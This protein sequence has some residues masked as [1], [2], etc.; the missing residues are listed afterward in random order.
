MEKHKGTEKEV[1]KPLSPKKRGQG[2]VAGRQG[3]LELQERMCLRR[4]VQRAGHRGAG[5]ISLCLSL[6]IL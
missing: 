1:I 3:E 5:Q 2:A 4:A 6:T